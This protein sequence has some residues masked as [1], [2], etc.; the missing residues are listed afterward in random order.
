VAVLLQ[1]GELPEGQGTVEERT[2]MVEKR[3]I[4][5]RQECGLTTKSSLFVLNVSDP[6]LKGIVIRAGGSDSKTP[7]S[8]HAIP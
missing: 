2:V 6:A 4:S 7:C 8:P 5:L 3:A 1:S